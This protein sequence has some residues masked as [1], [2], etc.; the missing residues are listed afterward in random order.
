MRFRDWL[1]HWFLL[2][3][4]DTNQQEERLT[5]FVGTLWIIWKYRNIQ[6]FKRQCPTP[7]SIGTQLQESRQQHLDFQLHYNNTITS[8]LRDPAVPPGFHV[9]TFGG[10]PSSIEVVILHIQGYRERRTHNGGIAWLSAC[11]AQQPQHYQG[12]FCHTSSLIYTK[13]Q[14][15]L[16]ALTWAMESGLSMVWILT[17]SHE[18]VQSLK[19]TKISNI[20]IRWTLSS[21]DTL[22]TQFPVRSSRSQVRI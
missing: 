4:N 6:I 16:Q 11:T 17:D 5:T 15:C 7:L 20:D 22:V 19:I 12:H 8:A 13:A 21:L 9:V 2:F 10:L 3:F 14:A 1:G 18:L